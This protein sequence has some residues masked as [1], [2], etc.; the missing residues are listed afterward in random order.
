VHIDL[1]GDLRSFVGQLSSYIGFLNEDWYTHALNRLINDQEYDPEVYLLTRLL[2]QANQ[3]FRMRMQNSVVPDPTLV[4]KMNSLSG[5]MHYATP[6]V[7]LSYKHLAYQMKTEPIETAVSAGIVTKILTWGDLVNHCSVDGYVCGKRLHFLHLSM[8]E[9]AGKQS[10]PELLGMFMMAQVH[11]G[12]TMSRYPEIV[13]DEG[14][15]QNP[16]DLLSVLNDPM[17]AVVSSDEKTLETWRGHESLKWYRY[18]M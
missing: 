18:N 12:R 17:F 8:D 15:Y 9:K 1:N 4:G 6:A 2:C 3:Y 5:Q 16:T 7:W 14:L 10:D 13:V 11:D